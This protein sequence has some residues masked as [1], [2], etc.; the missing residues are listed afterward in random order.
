MI[1]NRQVH[2]EPLEHW[3]FIQKPDKQKLRV[4]GT[5]Q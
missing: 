4:K 2:F 3:H 5:G 1:D